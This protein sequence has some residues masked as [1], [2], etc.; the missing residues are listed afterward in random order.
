[1][2]DGV[3][4]RDG[5][6]EEEGYWCELRTINEECLDKCFLE[7]GTVGDFEQHVSRDASVRRYIKLLI[8][9]F[10]RKYN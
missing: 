2:D 7:P 8:P 3:C 4:D 9:T 10:R 6:V 5:Q 1:M